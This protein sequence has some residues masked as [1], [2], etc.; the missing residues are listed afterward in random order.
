MI[1]NNKQLW[2]FTAILFAFFVVLLI[3]PGIIAHSGELAPGL[4]GDAGKNMFAYL[5]HIKHDQGFWFSGMNYPYGEHITFVDGQPLLSVTVSYFKTITFSQALGIMWSLIGISY[6][7]GIVYIYKILRHYG[8]HPLISILGA[9]LIIAINPQLYRS[10]GHFGLAYV[11][12]IPMV[13]FWSVKYYSNPI[14]KYP[15]YIMA[16]T[17][18]VVFLHPYLAA[19]VIIWCSLYTVGYLLFHNERSIKRR[20]LK[21]ITLMSAPV[22][23]T[24]LFNIV[25]S[26]TDPVKDRPKT[27][28]GITAYC[29]RGDHIFTAH[30][31][32]IWRFFEEHTS[33]VKNTAEQEGFCYLGLTTIVILLISIGLGVA[34]KIKKH[35]Y[36]DTGSKR[37]EPIWF[38]IASFA[39]V[40]SMGVPFVWNMEWLLQYLTFF[41]PFRTLGRFSWIFFYITTIYSIIALSRWLNKD[42]TSGKKNRAI[43]LGCIA[44]ALWTYE[45]SGYINIERN[46]INS[47]SE[48]Y[49]RIIGQEPDNWSSFLAQHGFKGAEFQATLLFR[50]FNVGTDKLWLGRDYTNAELAVMLQT[51]M[52]LGLPTINHMAARTSWS[53]AKKQVKIAGGPFVAKPTLNELPNNNPLLLINHE[54]DELDPDQKYIVEN[55]TYIGKHKEWQV[56]ACYPDKIIAADL[57]HNKAMHAIADNI[58][59]GDSCI[60]NT[61]EYY[62][63]HFD[64]QKARPTMWGKGAQPEIE[65]HEAHIVTIPLK[66]IKDNQLYEFSCWFLLGDENYRS[67]YFK[68]DMLDANGVSLKTQDVL[69]KESADNEGM[70]FR[71]NLF[72][73]IPANT[74]SIKCRLFNDPEKAYKVMDELMLRPADA[75][76]ISKSVLG[77][78][79]V[80]N[81]PVN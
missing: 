52:Q 9:S 20:Y 46:A 36:Q 5:F 76:I 32:P 29:T 75:V 16:L 24:I 2:L 11:C 68:L 7:L 1:N 62:I 26:I 37:F 61:G 45:A 53:I 39:L 3:F 69:T 23:A 72:F 66:P 42:Y 27:P 10:L 30:Y 74:V 73:T 28:Y 19:L 71:A 77:K 33:V 78:L 13:F 56:Y 25:M 54:G 81:H 47:S 14:I 58:I 70:W 44:L 22:M 41:R 57:A 63:N 6:I 60:V 48:N 12:V 80:N 38:F 50:Y 15:A 55:A 35:P 49:A 31:S 51:G 21:T 17:T 59:A 8:V 64:S 40:L 34:N 65:Q 67:P 4:G 79:L 43:V 18:I